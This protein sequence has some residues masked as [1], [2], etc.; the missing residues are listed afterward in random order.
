MN[1]RARTHFMTL[2]GLLLV[3]CVASASSPNGTWQGQ[4]DCAQGKTA[5]ALTITQAGPGRV[6]ALF[7][8]HALASNPRVP[9]GCFTM[10][11]HYEAAGRRI[12]LQPTL[13]LLQP[14]HFVW[15]GLVGRIGADGKG[16]TGRITGPGCTR[17]ALAHSD[18]PVTPPPPAACRMERNGPTV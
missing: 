5:L 13:W 4:Y 9:S 15:I 11:G 16:M 7:Y 2:A 17:F 3:S 1:W 10:T 6:R 12:V 8:F 18:I 14:A